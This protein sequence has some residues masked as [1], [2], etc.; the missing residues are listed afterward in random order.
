MRF[1]IVRI[2]AANFSFYQRDIPQDLDYTKGCGFE[3]SIAYN[4]GSTLAPHGPPTI[5]QLPRDSQQSFGC[6]VMPA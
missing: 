6:D 4:I 2:F 3:I 1:N 5:D